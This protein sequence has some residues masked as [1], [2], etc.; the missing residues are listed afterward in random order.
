MSGFAYVIVEPMVFLSKD[1]ELTARVAVMSTFKV[2]EKHHVVDYIESLNVE[3]IKDVCRPIRLGILPFFQ[4]SLPQ[5][6]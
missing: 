6:E 2:C 4:I 5:N 1:R 3:N